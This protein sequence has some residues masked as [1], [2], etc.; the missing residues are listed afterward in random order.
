MDT[1]LWTLYNEHVILPCYKGRL[2]PTPIRHPTTL[3]MLKGPLINKTDGGPVRLSNEAQ[4]IDFRERMAT[5][6]MHILLSLP[7][8]TECTAELD[9]LYSEFKPACKASTK[10]VAGMKMIARVEARKKAQNNKNERSLLEDLED[11]LEEDGEE[12]NPDESDAESDDE[13]VPLIIGNSVCSV[14]VGNRDLGNIVNGFPGEPIEKRPFD[15]IFQKHKILNFWIAVGFLPMTRNSIT[16]PKVRYELGEGGAPEKE[17]R[18]LELLVSEYEEA[19]ETLTRL[20]F[21]GG[22]LDLQARTAEERVI[23][24]EEE[25]VIQAIL[26]RKIIN[27]PGG[28]FKVGISVVNCDVMLEAARRTVTIGK[29]K[30]RT[31]ALK[32]KEDEDEGNDNAMKHYRKWLVDGSPLDNTNGGPK[33]TKEASKSIVKLLIRRIAPNELLKDYQSMKACV[34]W[35]GSVAGGTTWATEMEQVVEEYD[36]AETVAITPTVL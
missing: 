27:R 23:P 3:K 9:Q 22:V 11:Y 1:S 20:G 5:L 13:E 14:T 35:L 29:E 4:S 31:K 24:D 6:G 25:A 17:G 8:G 36:A 2:S 26:D 30:E 32:K 16:D 10:R 28:L 33:L 34:K 12:G 21:N 19:R 7:N 15:W 18:R